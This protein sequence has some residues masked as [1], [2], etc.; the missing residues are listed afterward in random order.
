MKKCLRAICAPYGDKNHSKRSLFCLPCAQH[1]AKCFTYTIEYIFEF[2]SEK[3]CEV[4]TFFFSVV[5]MRKARL[6]EVAQPKVHNKWQ[7]WDLHHN[8]A[9]VLPLS[10]TTHCMPSFKSVVRS[11]FFFLFKIQKSC[12]QNFGCHTLAFYSS[13]SLWLKAT[14]I[15]QMDGY[16]DNLFLL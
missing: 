12:F 6:R 10:S 7:T 5:Q 3:L 14:L 9:H 11:N 13:L 15:K 16:D 4:A 1:S 8:K 2:N